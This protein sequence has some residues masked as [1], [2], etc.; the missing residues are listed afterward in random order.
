MR[1][2]TTNG[3][4]THFP[5]E[6]NSETNSETKQ[7]TFQMTL[8]PATLTVSHGRTCLRC[9]LTSSIKQSL[10]VVLEEEVNYP[11]ITARPARCRRKYHAASN[12]C[13]HSQRPETLPIKLPADANSLNSAIPSPPAKKRLK[14]R[15][16]RHYIWDTGG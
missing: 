2:T 15:Q 8:E 13:L 11:E 16:K 6:T 5:S 4:S 1:Q 14:K 10:F 7:Q 3:Q 9:S 12:H